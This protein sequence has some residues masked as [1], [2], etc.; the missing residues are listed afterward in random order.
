MTVVTSSLIKSRTSKKIDKQGAYS[1]YSGN[2]ET[3]E[4]V[5]LNI[6]SQ[7]LYNEQESKKY[8]LKNVFRMS[9]EFSLKNYENGK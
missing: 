7:S 1:F 8:L 4:N 3:S 2:F 9:Y 5:C 6:L